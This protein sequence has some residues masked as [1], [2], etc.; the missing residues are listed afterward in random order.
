VTEVRAG[1]TASGWAA[2]RRQSDLYLRAS[3][4]LTACLTAVW[5]FFVVTGRDGGTVFKGYQVDLEA[6]VRV[7]VGLSIMTVLWGWLWYGVKRLLLRKLAGF[8][9]EELRAVFRSRLAEPFDLGALLRRHS[10]RRVRIA[11][12]IGRRGRFFTIGLLGYGYIYSRV[13]SAPTPDFLFVGLQESLFDAIVYSWLMLA[14]YHSNGF[15]GRVAYGAQARVMDGTLGRANCLVITMLWSLFKLFMVPLGSQLAA[16]FSP[17]TYAAL[18]AFVWLSYLGGDGLSEIVG[19]LFGKQK[20]RVWGIGEV[21]RKSVAGTWACFLG[22][23]A[24]CLWLVH[25]DGLGPAW[26]GLAVAVSLSNTF[27][28]LFSPRGT[29]DFTMASANAL[30]CWAFGGLVL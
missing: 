16:L 11:D 6:V 13:R 19:Q 23:L 27:F 9:E 7:A 5:L 28:E 18:F 25:A 17:Q 12:M 29:D 2:Y 10:E 8:S 14:L 24:I 26:V 4:A 21:N 1:G 22:S 3:V 30:L 20:L 15:L